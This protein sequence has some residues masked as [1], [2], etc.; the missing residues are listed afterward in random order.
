MII[1]LINFKPY[2]RGALKGF[3]DLHIDILTISGCSYFEK[4][5]KRWFTFPN[6]P[7]EDKNGQ[8]AYQ[9]IIQ[10]TNA[11]YGH[12]RAEVMRQIDALNG[13][14]EKSRHQSSKSYQKDHRTPEGEDLSQHYSSK[15]E[16]IPF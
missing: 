1:E 12:L 3:F 4:D 7:Y 2:Q 6:K 15:D 5:G 10:T 14:P 8:T 13:N 9:E 16:D 11:I